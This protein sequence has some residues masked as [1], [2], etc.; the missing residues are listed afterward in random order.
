MSLLCLNYRGCGWPEAVCKICNVV[1]HNRPRVLFLS[2][3]RMSAEHSQNLC[4]KLGFH[5]AFGVSSQG[6]SG[7]LVMMWKVDMNVVIKTFSKFHIDV[8]IMESDGMMWRFTGFYGEP[9]RTL[10]RES[11]HM[12]RFLRNEL[13]LPWLC[14]GD[15]N[16]TLDGSEQIGGNDRQEWCMDGF[17]EAVEY[18]DLWDL[19]YSGLPYTWD[20]RR[21]GSAN[22][23]VRLDRALANVA[24]LDLY[25]TVVVMHSIT[26]L[27]CPD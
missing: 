11:L 12:L 4:W 18:C 10:R 20:N 7:G 2:E 15:F 5:N 27:W 14:S 25:D 24:R 8:W 17:W 26:P 23:K 1:D 3:T 21:E 13:A 6:F 9:K 22:I 19:G 16:E